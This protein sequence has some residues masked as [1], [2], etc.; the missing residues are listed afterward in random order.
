ME[1]FVDDGIVIKTSPTGESDLVVWILTRTRGIIRAFAKGA[2][3]TKNRLHGAASLFAYCSFSITEKNNVFHVN[4]AEIK[5][6]FFDLRGSLEKLTVAQYLCEV[7]LKTVPD[8]NGDEIF[9]RI[10]L[11][12]LY[13]LCKSEKPWQQIKAVFELRMASETGYMPSLVACDDCGEY[14]S[15]IMYFDVGEGKLYCTECGKYKNLPDIPA[16]VVAA[17]RHIVFSP[18]EKMFA[19]EL[20]AE[21]YPVLCRMT[22][23]YLSS[24]TR[25]TFRTLEYL[26][27]SEGD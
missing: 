3:G 22:E 27:Y 16:A 6:I 12:S 5:E 9:L 23:R 24:C 15:D 13:F 20:T 8:D 11:N 2:R 19:F 21:L 7:M 18:F 26:K 10:I 14:L 25:Q 1:K 17:M 4:E